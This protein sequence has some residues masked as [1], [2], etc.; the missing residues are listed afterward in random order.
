MDLP[1][2][3]ADPIY[4]TIRDVVFWIEA[5]LSR[6]LTSKIIA[7]RAGYT[8]WHLQRA[9]KRITGYT[10][11]QYIRARRM[12][13]AAQLLK[14]TNLK[15]SEIYTQIGY[16]DGPTFSRPFRAHFGVT[17]QTLRKSDDNFQHRMVEQLVFD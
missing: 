6:T 8:R 3:I 9:F 7:D 4:Q 10:L 2:N 17:P 14:S 5:D 12:T 11:M 13:T 16:E 1:L 15:I